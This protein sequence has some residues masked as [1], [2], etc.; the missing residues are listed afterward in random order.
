[1]GGFTS[2]VFSVLLGWIRTAA[3]FLWDAV[4]S[5]DGGGWLAWLADHWL[6]LTII[7]CGAGIVIDTIVYLLRWRPDRVWRS[8]FRRLARR[9][10]SEEKAPSRRRTVHRR[11]LYADGSER[12][13]EVETEPLPEEPEAW[14]PGVYQDEG[15]MAGYAEPE[16]T[17][18]YDE[19][20]YRRQFA[21][22]ETEARQTAGLEGYPQPAVADQEEPRE[23]ENRSLRQAARRIP[24]AA[25]QQFFASHD[26]DEL[27]LRYRPAQPAVSKEQAYNKPYYPPQW[28]PPAE[29]GSFRP[30]E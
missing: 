2:G 12:F 1:M 28:K 11:W 7:I 18:A 17:P 16:E 8:F 10:A 29:S 5:P 30:E 3:V 13:E 25:L 4:T 21:R 27:D 20:A 23:R 24:A 15:T 26:E 9:G 22:P 19:E 14:Q 6:T